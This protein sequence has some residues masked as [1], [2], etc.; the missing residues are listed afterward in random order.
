MINRGVD[1]EYYSTSSSREEVV[2]RSSRRCI[3]S[4]CSNHVICEN[5]IQ[6]YI[7]IHIY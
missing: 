3:S 1:G 2:V 6:I 5:I 4:S 7:Y